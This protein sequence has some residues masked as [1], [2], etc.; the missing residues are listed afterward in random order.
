MNA[1]C[2]I[3]VG[4]QG[5]SEDVIDRHTRLSNLSHDKPHSVIEDKV[6]MEVFYFS[7]ETWVGFAIP[8]NGL[9]VGIDKALF[10]VGSLIYLTKEPIEF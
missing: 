4:D 3:K 8:V 5:I 1:S 9:V 6:R 10:D 7:A 2:S